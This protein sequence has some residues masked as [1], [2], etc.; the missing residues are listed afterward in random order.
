MLE[1]W[2]KV[3][4]KSLGH[5]LLYNLDICKWWDIELYTTVTY[6]SRHI[7]EG[8]W[9]LINDCD[10]TQALISCLKCYTLFLLTSCLELCYRDR[11]SVV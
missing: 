9:A 10:S 1:T 5:R 3:N 4:L 11:K 7:A 6:V 8:H 2:D